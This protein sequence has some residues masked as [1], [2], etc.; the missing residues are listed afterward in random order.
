MRLAPPL[1]RALPALCL[2]LFA[3]ACA[4]LGAAL[5][6]PTIEAASDRRAELRLLAPGAGRPLGG[7]A[8]RLHARVAN[9][10]PFGL[11]LSRVDG[12]LFLEETRAAR[13]DLPL[14]LP[15]EAGGETVVPVDV[16]LSFSDLPGLAD[17]ATRALSGRPLAYRVHGTFG[18]DAGV[19]GTPT[20]GPSTLLAGEMTVLR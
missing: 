3:G 19:F 6:P 8:I 12:D 14:G 7:A 18:V 9:P 1:R 10:N 13:V 11:T 15:L 20:F 2:L 5:V 16:S 4:T 17:V